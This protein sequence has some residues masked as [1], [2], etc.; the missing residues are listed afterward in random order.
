MEGIRI[1]PG[2]EEGEGMV[3]GDVVFEG[4][5]GIR[6]CGPSSWMGMNKKSR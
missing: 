1:T 6:S 5:A 2:V 3:D 4:R